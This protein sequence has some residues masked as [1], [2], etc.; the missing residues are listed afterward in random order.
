MAK[1]SDK[2]ADHQFNQIQKGTHIEGNLRS[3]SN[4]RLDGTFVGNLETKGKLV[5]G[6]SGSIE[7]EVSCLNAEIEGKVNGKII[8]QDLL[9][10][11][12]SAVLDGDIYTGNLN[13]EPG[14]VFN[15]SASMGNKVKQM[16]HD[17]QAGAEE[18]TA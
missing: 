13:I 7:G 12:S 14:A 2:N 16:N 18:K 1:Q 5:I 15:G 11:K 6:K 9:S 17:E 4:I 10:L 3:D 8:V